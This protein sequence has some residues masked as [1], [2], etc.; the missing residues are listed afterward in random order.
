MT[1]A[2]TGDPRFFARTGPYALA[3][4]ALAAVGTAPAMERM[5]VGVAPLQSAGLDEVSSLDNR[6]YA[7]A[8]QQTMAGAVILPPQ[9]QARV[10]RSTIA[11]VTIAAYE[12]WARVTALFHP[13]PAPRPGIHPSALIDPDARVDSSAEIGPYT[14]VQARAE[15]GSGCRIGSFVSVGTGVTMGQ[16]CRIGAHVGLP[17]CLLGSRVYI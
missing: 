6:R 4:I 15:I 11:I 9:T 1:E 5:F 13:V 10:P 8:L 2:S 17:H 12:G 14:V 16:D 3:D 7:A